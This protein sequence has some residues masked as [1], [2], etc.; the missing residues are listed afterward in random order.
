MS[1]TASPLPGPISVLAPLSAS[2]SAMRARCLAVGTLIG[3]TLD[4]SWDCIRFLITGMRCRRTPSTSRLGCRYNNAHA[5]APRRRPKPTAQASPTMNIWVPCVV[6]QRRN[7]RSIFAAI[8]SDQL[9]RNCRGQRTR[10][11][12]LCAVINAHKWEK[13]RRYKGRAMSPE[14]NRIWRLFVC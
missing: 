9:R 1:L 2:R 13:R 10:N 12:F 8:P 4:A 6:Q 3:Q 14:R 7:R 5:D 11:R